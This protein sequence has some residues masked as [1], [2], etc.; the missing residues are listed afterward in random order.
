MSM[1]SR[2]GKGEVWD[3]GVKIAVR[4]REDIP[5]GE[6]KTQCTKGKKLNHCAGY[7]VTRCWSTAA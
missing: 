1:E 6:R 5:R 3:M 4:M 7:C 2:G